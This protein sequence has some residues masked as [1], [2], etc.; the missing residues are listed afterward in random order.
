MVNEVG[1]IHARPVNVGPAI[2]A[3]ASAGAPSSNAVGQSKEPL[4]GPSAESMQLSALAR[5]AG[6]G[7]SLN[8]AASMVRYADKAMAGVEQLLGEMREPLGAIVKMYPPYPIDNPQRIEYLNKYTQLRHQID[9]LTIPPDNQRLGKLIADPAR[10]PGAGDMEIPLLGDSKDA[11]VIP[12]KP[13]Y[14]GEGGLELPELP[15]ESS[16][17]EVAVAAQRVDDAQYYVSGQRAKMAE[18]LAQ[19]IG[20]INEDLANDQSMTGR[21]LLADAQGYTV[22]PN[23]GRLDAL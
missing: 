10:L 9:A 6:R 12:A 21:Q 17:E 8:D 20:R 22:L 4:G 23:T 1:G 18:E 2:T 11:V 5:A 19:Y 3:T 14:P 7:I 16:D 13:M 15:G